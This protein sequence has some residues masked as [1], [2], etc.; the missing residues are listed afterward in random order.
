MAHEDNHPQTERAAET[1]ARILDAAL[2]E[3][4]AHGMAGARTE[5]IAA[6]A[7]VNKA[8][9]YYYFESK[10]KLYAAALEMSAGRIRDSSMEVF[11]RGGTAGERV[12]RTALNH[13]DRILGQQEFQSLM[14][15]EM[16]RLHKGE[17]DAMSILV[18]RVFAP[19]TTMYQALVREGIAS[20][21]LIDVDWLQMH[22][23]TLGANVFYFLSAPIWRK[24][25]PHDPLDVAVLKKRRKA[26]LEFLGQAIFIHRKHGA[27]VAAKVFADTPMPEIPGGRLELGRKL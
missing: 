26:L 2:S 15:Q 13:F 1:R 8:L 21:E 23:A 27:A 14:Q 24:V 12:L 7:G 11:L 10:E 5:R 18:N 16:I 22:L 20:G 25:L 3:F 9:L 17:S 4:A 6:A 19:L